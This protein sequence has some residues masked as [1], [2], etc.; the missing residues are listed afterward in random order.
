MSGRLLRAVWTL[1]LACLAASPARGQRAEHF[2][3]V[4]S[5]DDLLR[6]GIHRPGD[7]LRLADGWHTAS[8]EGFSRRATAAGL[9]P[10]DAP[11]WRVLLD[12]AEAPIE[13]PSG[14]E[15]NLLPFSL[16]QI[17][18]VVITRAP[19]LAGGDVAT[20]GVIAFYTRRPPR[21]VHAHAEGWAGNETGDPGPFYY[22][23]AQS[24]NIDRIGPHLAAGV[25]AAGR[26]FSAA[27]SFRSDEH[28]ATDAQ[29]IER[30]YGLYNDARR[31]RI[32]L[33]APHG[34]LAYH[35]GAGRAQLSGG[36]TSLR[37]LAYLEPAGRE[38]PTHDRY[39]YGNLLV[40]RR[41]GPR[42]VE[43]RTSLS[44]L[45][46]S[47]RPNRRDVWMDWREQQARAHL[48]GAWQTGAARLTADLA[49]SRRELIHGRGPSSAGLVSARLGAERTTARGGVEAALWAGTARGRPRRGSWPGTC[50]SA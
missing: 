3:T 39:A 9:S 1:A 7:V 22:V 15:L 6:E 19:T 31:P 13:T 46:L 28:H 35:G 30:V 24:P 41:W 49:V 33:R 12:G 43:F 25:S 5:H 11:Q 34:V 2:R 16:A 8:V 37:N 17:D 32:L 26:R 18:S 47:L 20:G 45:R 4:L 44:A 48:A 14:P 36:Y 27:A 23:G 10:L 29:Q 42:S 40:G 21:G 50:R 38:T